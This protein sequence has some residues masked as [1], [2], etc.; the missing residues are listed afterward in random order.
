ML[1]A[2]FITIIKREQI[3]NDGAIQLDL[4]M[5]I[6]TTPRTVRNVFIIGAE[7]LLVKTQS[8]FKFTVTKM[9]A[10]AMCSAF[11]GNKSIISI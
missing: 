1:L 5:P 7:I 9:L 10:E 2:L 3:E 6:M 4:H 11:I 8:T